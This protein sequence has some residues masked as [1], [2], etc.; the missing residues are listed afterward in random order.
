MS[1]RTPETLVDWLVVGIAPFLIMMLVGSL[2]FYLVE[3]FYLGDY[4]I[5]LLF[6]LGLFVMAIVCVARIS[7]EDGGAYAALF[8]VPLAVAV[9]VAIATFVE[10]SGPLAPLGPALNWALMALVWWAAHKLTWDCTLIEGGRDFT[11]QGLMQTTGLDRFFTPK[12]RTAETLE[13]PE[14]AAPR[15]AG[16]T[17][18]APPANLPVWQ[19]WLKRDERPHAPGVWVVYFSLAALPLFGLGQWFIPAADLALRR[20]TFWLLV[21]Y[22]AAGLALLLSTSFLSLR[23]YLRQRK[24]EMPLEMAGIWLCTGVAMIVALLIIASLLPRPIPEYSITHL[25]PEIQ[26]PDRSASRWGWGKEGAKAQPDSAQTA[27]KGESAQNSEQSLAEGKGSPQPSADGQ[28]GSGPPSSSSDS[29]KTSVGKQDQSKQGE[30]GS[31]SDSGSSSQSKQDNESKEGSQQQPPEDKPPAET[32]ASKSNEQSQ[33]KTDSESSPQNEQPPPTGESNPAPPTQTLSQRA[34][35]L[36]AYLMR[37]LQW[38]FYLLV[39]LVIGYFAWQHRQ[40]LWAAWQQLLA[41]LRELWARWFGPEKKQAEPLAPVALAPQP[42]RFAEYADPFLSGL[43]ARWSLAELVRYTFEALEARG[44]E[45]ACPRGVDQTPL[46]YAAIVGQAEPALAS[47]FQRLAD[48]YGQL[49]FARG[50]QS[51][52]ALAQLQQLWQRWKLG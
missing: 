13:N 28:S 3:V 29:E 21:I 37:L 17:S 9:G 24:L 51:P 40:R 39:V 44:R 4:Q 50:L 31:K 22:V 43:A 16:T 27:T 33:P 1:R 30:Q 49:A 15:L 32:E 11:G 14:S 25:A 52:Q 41:E 36:F 2:V 19:W 20:R 46:E 23:R 38:L 42:K 26:S 45:R 18:T 8:G 5:R 35:Q 34:G 7:M 12:V 47:E 10:V 6:V 48:L